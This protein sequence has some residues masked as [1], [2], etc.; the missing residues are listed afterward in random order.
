MQKLTALK[1]IQNNVIVL[2]EK[3][4]ESRNAIFGK[5]VSSAGEVYLA[6]FGEVAFLKN[7]FVEIN[8]E[9][10]EDVEE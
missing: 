4:A 9:I 10:T 7:K 6:G 2:I 8:E 1:N 5:I 3:T